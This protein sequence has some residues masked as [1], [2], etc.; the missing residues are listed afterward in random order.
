MDKFYTYIVECSDGTYYTGWT[1]NLENRIKAHNNGTGAKYTKTRTPVSLIYFE[2]L[3]SKSLAMKRE[4][5]IKKLSRKKKELL[6]S[7]FSTIY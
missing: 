5:A 3:E 7:S 1:V 4:A 2:V 6:I